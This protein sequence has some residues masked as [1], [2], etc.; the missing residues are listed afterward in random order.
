MN[1][2][3]NMEI[4]QKWLKSAYGNNPIFTNELNGIENI[5]KGLIQGLQI[6]LGI[7]IEGVWN[8]ETLDTFEKMFPEGLNIKTVKNKNIISI[9]KGGIYVVRNISID[10]INGDFSEDLIIAIKIFQKQIGLIENGIITAQLLKAI[11]SLTSY[12]LDK[13]GDK[14]IREIQQN[15]NRKYHKYIGLIQTNGIY[16]TETNRALR[17]VIEMEL[18]AIENNI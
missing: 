13:D 1:K 12:E 9:V 18:G 6:E 15:L 17:K 10:E 11:L 5:L 3:K 16:G 2:N 7:T 8:K 14:E 4:L